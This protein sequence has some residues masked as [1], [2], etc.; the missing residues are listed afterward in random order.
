MSKN[1]Y[2]QVSV[3]QTGA[4]VYTVTKNSCNTS[5]VKLTLALNLEKTFCENDSNSDLLEI[6]CNFFGFLFNHIAKLSLGILD[7][8]NLCLFSAGAGI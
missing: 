1:K 7:G 8:K 2:L 3:G 4:L 5:V 6:K